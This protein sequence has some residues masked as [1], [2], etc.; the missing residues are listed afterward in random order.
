MPRDW[1]GGSRRR[2]LEA[3]SQSWRWKQASISTE[4]TN[5]SM[6]G[7][8]EDRW[9]H[10]HLLRLYIGVK[11]FFKE[12]F[13][14]IFAAIYDRLL[15]SILLSFM[16]GSTYLCYLEWQNVWTNRGQMVA[17]SSPSSSNKTM[18]RSPLLRRIMNPYLRSNMAA[19]H[20]WEYSWMEA[21]LEW[22]QTF[23]CVDNQWTDGFIIVSSDYTRELS[24]F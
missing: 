7:Q 6:R 11:S 22:Q 10:H 23:P 18:Q 19:L 13:E 16:Y 3:Y 5:F 1:W 14:P 4:T 21:F 17:S 15:P 9:F 24:I 20:V 8:T 12:N 2:N